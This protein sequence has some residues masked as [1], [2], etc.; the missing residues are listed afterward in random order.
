MRQLYRNFLAMLSALDARIR[1]LLSW[2]EFAL[3]YTRSHRQ[4]IR[5]WPDT[6][7]SP[8]PKVAIFVHF[9]GQGRVGQHVLHYVASLRDAGFSVLFV[10]N[11]GKLREDAMTAL[12]PLCTGILIRRNIGYDFGAMREGLEYLGLPRADTQLVLLVNDSIYGPLAPLEPI[13]ARIDL[14]T[15]DLWGATESWQARYHLQS[16]F[17]AAGRAA[18]TS[19]AWHRFWRGVRPVKSK[20]WV[21][22]HY[23]IGLTQCLLRAGIRCAALWSYK[24]LVRNV[25]VDTVTEQAPDDPLLKMRHIHAFRIRHYAATRT[26]LN[27]NSDLWRQL[28]LGGFP[29]IKRELIRLNPSQVSDVVDWR[30]VVAEKY[31][32]IPASIELDFQRTMRNK[33]P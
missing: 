5:A 22:R 3:S 9:D 16:F 15:A 24:D 11:S 21:I 25:D 20:T 6:P 18:L 26:P 2:V 17:L 27:P 29:F 13:L 31:G 1:R 12:K 32:G 8:G 23:E 28:L 7:P 10:T 4:I 30:D 33:V 14:E 19:P